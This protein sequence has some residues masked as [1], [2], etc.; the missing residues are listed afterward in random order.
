MK[1][2]FLCNEL[3][4]HRFFRL[5]FVIFVRISRRVSV[6]FVQALQIHVQID[7]I[8]SNSFVIGSCQHLC[9]IKESALKRIPP[10]RSRSVEETASMSTYRVGSK[11]PLYYN[12]RE[13]RFIVTRSTFIIAHQVE[14]LSSSYATL[15]FGFHSFNFI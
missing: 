7:S 15:D 12:N 8:Y 1:F 9:L 6:L 3:S 11:R 4:R 13:R 5:D 10:E 14:M 2:E